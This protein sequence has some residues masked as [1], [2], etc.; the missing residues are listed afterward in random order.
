MSEII[1][2]IQNIINAN[3]I[4]TVSFDVFD[5]LVFRR[6]NHPTDI[7]VKAYLSCQPDVNLSMEGEEFKELRIYA[8]QQ[9]KRLSKSGEVSLEQ[10]YQFL[11]FEAAICE[12]LKDAEL[13][14]EKQNAFLFQPMLSLIQALQKSGKQVILISDMYLSQ[15]QIR[16]C[17]FNDYPELIELALYV[18]SE[19][20]FNKSTGLIFEHL[21]QSLA[22]NKS[23]WLHIGDNRNSDFLMPKKAG[24]D[25][26]WLSA[27]LDVER[28]FSLE[29][30][31]FS[32]KQ[33]FN[34]ARFIS[35]SHFM[36]DQEALAFN[37][38]SMVWGPILFSFTD[39]VIDHTLKVESESILCLMREAEV[40]L[41][42]LE[43]RLKQ[44]Q[45][46]HIVVKKLYASRK[47]TFWAAIDLANKSWFEDLVYVLV[48]RRGYT[49]DDFYR[50]FFIQHDAI[51]A[52][53]QQQK[54]R[55]T[56]GLFYL[57]ENLLKLLT[58]IARD[59]MAQLEGHIKQQKMLFARYYSQQI[60][61][62]FAE[63]VVLDL[64]GGGTIQHQIERILNQKSKSNVL[65]YSSERIYRFS[66]NSRYASFLNK[67]TD[68]R[69]LRQI[70]ARSPECIEPFLV[71]DCGT[72]L[73]Y[74][75]NP[76]GNPVLA[77]KL[78]LNSAPILGFM[79]GVMRYFDLHDELGFGPIS[80][81]QVVPILYRYI[82]LPTEQE[83]KLFTRIL[84][85]DNFGSNDEYPIITPEQLTQI[86]Q[87]GID[88][89]YLEF[90]RNP[91]FLLGKVHWPQ[92]ALTLMSQHYLA[93][94]NGILSMNTDNDVA[95]LV[96]RILAC[97]WQQFSVY[98]AGQFFE[99]LLPHLIKHNLKVEYLI[100][101]KAEI[102]GKYHVAGFDVIS[103]ESA[104]LCKANKIVISSYAFKN[105]I[106]RNI[107][108]RSIEHDYQAV[109]VLSL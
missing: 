11:P 53:Y 98:G 36:P 1:A 68:T 62:P 74:E 79:Q 73:G 82:Q 92:A 107:Y 28:I 15:N 61:L 34:S 50:D 18:S 12:R 84:H 91:R 90:C 71:G 72:T 89:F 60:G 85:Q 96:E 48:Q 6:S 30:S 99:K 17:F 40:F 33:H 55:D 58:H 5:T 78:S 13:T 26:L 37:I 104:L 76:C 65:F 52:Q 4:Q 27:E 105:E 2:K 95:E 75:N 109:D 10:I 81:A 94:Q 14:A 23:H 8:E 20:E 44:R 69:N 70:L 80:I 7:F 86:E 3:N 102:S 9:A 97:G 21:S 39:W 77:E 22:I 67:Q 45:L 41:P 87:S 16:T 100:D 32:E 101:R 103:L 51:H 66:E 29:Q 19:N 88:S 47:S 38:G 108:D 42:L 83:A 46:N 43:T 56:D 57:G 64:G 93:K 106:A 49:V 54:I 31:L 63:C 25:A 35:S 59:N 24:I